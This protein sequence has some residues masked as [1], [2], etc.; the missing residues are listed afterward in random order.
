MLA[1][2]SRNPT[3]A[4][5]IVPAMAA[6]TEVDTSWT[7]LVCSASVTAA[8]IEPV[9]DFIKIQIEDKLSEDDNSDF[10]FRKKYKSIYHRTKY[11][12][13]DK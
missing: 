10:I 3:S 12:V 5:W 1:I 13:F 7:I 4:D 6:L 9:T 8:A 2:S 11:N